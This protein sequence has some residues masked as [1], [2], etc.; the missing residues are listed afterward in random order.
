M[1]V[2]CILRQKVYVQDIQK[3]VAFNFLAVPC[4][5]RYKSSN[6]QE[7]LSREKVLT[8][9]HQCIHVVTPS[10]VLCYFGFSGMTVVR[11]ALKWNFCSFRLG[12][13]QL[14]VSSFCHP[15]Q[16]YRCT[17][18]PHFQTC[19]EFLL[20]FTV[21]Y[22]SQFVENRKMVEL[23]FSQNSSVFILIQVQV[24]FYKSIDFQLWDKVEQV[25]RKLLH[26]TI[27][28]CFFSARIVYLGI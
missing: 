17:P 3:I 21:T 14:W 25:R 6:S 28:L 10:W 9:G 26:K 2:L 13:L 23:W 19:V 5:Y 1:S 4:V 16:V 12:N 27:N 11:A 15:S 24:Y 7:R 22:S 8:F 20:R 18:S